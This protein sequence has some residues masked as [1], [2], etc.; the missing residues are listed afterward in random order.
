MKPKQQ[1]NPVVI[2]ILGIAFLFILMRIFKTLTG[3]GDPLPP[4]KTEVEA[5]SSAGVAQP[6]KTQFAMQPAGMR[7]RD[8]FNHPYLIQVAQEEANKE[9]NRNGNFGTARTGKTPD[10]RRRYP[11]NIG[12]PNVTPP[13]YSTQP[14]LG[15]FAN[16]ASGSHSG[17]SSTN[18][19][20]MVSSPTSQSPDN[21]TA[22]RPNTAE[23][24]RVTAILGG[25][26]PTAIV[27]SADMSPRTVTV[28]DEL[29]GFRI[30]A[31][32]SD[33]IVVSSA[34]AVLTLP[35]ETQGETKD[36]KPDK[37]DT[38]GTKALTA[39]ALPKP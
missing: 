11:T 29:H 30:A 14:V 27:E 9:N 31:I 38:N 7:G 3:G 37:T 39:A 33:E 12:L 34:R 10:S 24:W 35:L 28:G 21:P 23:K 1:N 8:P 20:N 2:G 22:Q 36:E 15:G 26:H 25:S 4:A 13:T 19:T 6:V 32:R 17:N 16:N 18:N 5:E